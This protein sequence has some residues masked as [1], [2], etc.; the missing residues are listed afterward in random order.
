[1]TRVSKNSPSSETWD[2]QY[3]RYQ[4]RL[5]SEYLIPTL[6]DW[7]VSLTGKRFFEAGCGDGGCAAEFHRSGCQVTAVDIDERIVG[8]ARA[9]NDKEGMSFGTY[10]G[11]INREDCPGLDEGPFDIILMRDVVEHLEDLAAALTIMRQNLTESGVLFVV[12]PPYYSPYG[13]HQQILPR[14]TVGFIPY[15]K[16]PYIQLLPDRLFA[17]MTSGDSPFNEEVARLRDI[18]LTIRGFEHDVRQ[19][20][21]NVLHRKY[22]LTRPTH[23]LRYGVPVVGASILGRIP[24]LNEL[25][26]TACYYLLGTKKPGN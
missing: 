7:S 16:L 19:A 15:N 11:D 22:Y 1:M 2:E 17:A 18:R 9:L 6:G 10:V 21:L 24:F 26:V 12:F 25:A 3:R 23:R 14:K 20:G 5:A 4:A 8:I 13:A